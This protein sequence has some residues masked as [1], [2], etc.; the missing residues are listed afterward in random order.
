MSQNLLS[1][2]LFIAGT[3]AAS[4]C[5]AEQAESGQT[6]TE[7]AFREVSFATSDG[8]RVFA[9][10]YG[11]GDHGVV[12]AHGAIFD[13]ESWSKQAEILVTAGFRVL[14]ID[15]R[16]Y[17]K[18]KAGTE[19]N[20]LELDVLAA[21]SYLRDNGAKRVSV[22]GG[23]MGGGAA[24]QAAVKA[25]EGQIDRLVLLAHSPVSRPEKMTG[26]KLFIVSNGDSS[27]RSVQ[28]QY[29]TAADPKKL[30]IMPGDAHAQHIFKTKYSKQL[31]DHILT[32]LGSAEAK[33]QP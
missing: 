28:Q 5:E 23:S 14:A 9:N 7:Q 1:A 21:V 22:V 32:G 19:G 16:G 17:G 30:V 29:E 8:G 11:T 25:K 10:L 27:K 18:S 15:F 24:A 6:V 31:M 33:A 26:N 2:L 20:R 13:K 3:L 4:G 12:L